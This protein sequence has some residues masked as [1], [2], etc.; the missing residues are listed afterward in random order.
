MAHQLDPKPFFVLAVIAVIAVGGWFILGGGGTANY[1]D[2]AACLAEKDVTMYGFDLC[3]NC[4]KQKSKIGR[5]AF[6]QYLDGT[7][8]YVRCRAPPDGVAQQPI[9]ADRLQNITIL[10]R[11][12]GQVS[13]STTQ[14][15][16]CSMMVGRGTP[17]WL[18][19][20]PDTGEVQQVSG[21]RS[22]GRLA[23][24]SGCPVPEGATRQTADVEG[25]RFTEQ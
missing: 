5:D 6:K 1:D 8:R 14:G 23:E 13:A 22:V 16:L 25:K 19:P 20:A 10:P 18:I 9:G 11:H 7:G 15:E 12:N 17:T 21:W 3:P 4:N 2:L 24:L